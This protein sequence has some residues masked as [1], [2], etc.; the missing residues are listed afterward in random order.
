MANFNF[1]VD[2]DEMAHSIDGVSSHVNG[3]TAAVVAMQSAVIAA[4]TAAANRI[5]EQA[6]HGFRALMRSQITQKIARL[7]SEVD[8]R[9]IEMRQQGQALASI[10]T[11]M[12]HDFQMIANRYTRVFH[13]IDVSLRNRVF[14]L[15]KAAHALVH[16]EMERIRIRVRSL[17]AQAPMHQLESVQSIQMV[18]ASQT[19]ANANRA[20]RAMQSFLTSSSRQ[21]TLLA[22]MLFEE[23]PGASGL[24]YVPVLMSFSAGHAAA[25]SQWDFHAP[26][27]SGRL[28]ANVNA[29]LQS[30]A[31]AGLPALKWSALDVEAHA[32][33][34]A[35]FRRMVGQA[36]LNDRIQ[37]QMLSLYGAS[38]WE[39]TSGGR[40]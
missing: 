17:Q 39:T 30:V 19:K 34:S 28:A 15:D 37:S 18:A 36:G 9:F 13:S 3:V 24:R 16:R 38:A 31:Y 2:T 11:R 8:S 14:E 40:T 5:C 32:R 21:A 7:Q 22:S 35:E 1:T 29:G 10:R 25:G 12:E 23:A 20:I 4:E 33:T 26:H 27:S 6:T